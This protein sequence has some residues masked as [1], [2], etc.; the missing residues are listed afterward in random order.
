VSRSLWPRA[1]LQFL[2]LFAPLFTPSD[3]GSLILLCSVSSLTQ[4][5][6]DPCLHHGGIL[7]GCLWP[8]RCEHARNHFSLL[9][10]NICLCEPEQSLSIGQN[11][12]ER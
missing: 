10:Q 4:E 11:E 5:Y 12:K 7:L 6:L 3:P 2:S 1:A 9:F 8:D